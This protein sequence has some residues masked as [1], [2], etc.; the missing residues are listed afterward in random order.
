M[1]I[2]RLMLSN[3]L[4]YESLD[5][6]FRRTPVQVQGENRSQHDQRS[7]GACKS[8]IINAIEFALTGSC[9]RGVRDMELINFN[10]SEAHIHL[11]IDC[12][13]RSE[14][15]CIH[16][17][18]KSKG[19][20]ILEVNTRR[21]KSEEL[22]PVDY[23]TVNDGKKVILDWLAISKDDL[24]NY[25]IIT[26]ERFKSFFK[27]SSK[28][29]T[30]LIS[31]FT[32]A[33]II[34]GLDGSMDSDIEKLE[35]AASN[36]LEN[37]RKSASQIEVHKSNIDKELSRNLTQEF[38]EIKDG[39]DAQC[40]QLEQ[41]ANKSKED[42]EECQKKLA[43]T[44]TDTESL[45]AAVGLAKKAVNE[46]K[47]TDFDPIFSK[48]ETQ[49]KN[50]SASFKST[51][52][53][54]KEWRDKKSKL[55]AAIANLS[56]SLMGLIVCPNCG[57]EW[58]EGQSM[59]QDDIKSSKNKLLQQKQLI[60]QV[61]KLIADNQ[62]KYSSFQQEIR[63]LSAKVQSITKTQ[64][65]ENTCLRELQTN[66]TTALSRVELIEKQRKVLQNKIDNYSSEIQDNNRS[67]KRLKEEEKAL[68]KPVINKAL[69]KSWKNEIDSLESNISK[70]SEAIDDLNDK[71]LNLNEWKVNFKKFKLY[72]AN[73]S[74]GVIQNH[75]N[76]FLREMGSDM[77][78]KIS[79]YKYLANGDVKDD[80]T[81]IIIR[82]RERSFGSFSGG[83]KGR[84][85]FASILGN[86]HMID[87]A[88]PYGGLDFLGLDEV[89]EAVDSIGISHIMKSVK[90]FDCTMLIIT[91]V[92]DE[93]L[94]SDTIKIVKENERSFIVAGED[95]VSGI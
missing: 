83:E 22:I 57:Y 44:D 25:Y 66:L 55:D 80:I 91:H 51:E 69:I 20:N 54:L 47:S 84:L 23:S 70:N 13:V 67:M 17:T 52:T 2:S 31:R 41:D 21:F 86:K 40:L 15:L 28:E 72:V 58:D 12:Q 26:R 24:F 87:K 62:D 56:R 60:P 74:L 65:E 46:F 27:S 10:A 73:Q 75:M 6:T 49:E 85:I 36:A 77:R 53:E 61:E 95:S 78:I 68:I 3:F 71:L 38:Q 59:T 93:F 63:E 76:F 45:Q 9:S 29:N 81:P 30:E 92:S 34:E 50:L 82:E 18:I 1:R 64:R 48:L 14:T 32:D 19:S 90:Q 43:L 35:S 88:N 37:N 11:F 79:G 8:G 94:D 33:Q 16:W 4:T 7:N 39:F 42:I 89:F 5:Y